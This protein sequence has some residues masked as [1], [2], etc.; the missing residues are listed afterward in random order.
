MAPAGARRTLGGLGIAAIVVAACNSLSGLD[1]DFALA[2]GGTLP[3]EGGAE[4]SSGSSGTSGSSGQNDADVP[5]TKTD[6]SGD[7][8]GGLDCTNPPAGPSGATLLFCDNFDDAAKSGPLWGW[9]RR[10]VT[11]GEPKVEPDIGFVARGLHAKATT[12][13]TPPNGG[14]LTALWKTVQTGLQ[15]GQ[16]ITLGLRFKIHS[17]DVD[18]TVIGAIQLN[19]LEYGVALY[20]NPSCPG[21]GRCVDE[22]DHAGGHDFSNGVPLVLDAWYA[23]DITVTRTGSAFGGKVV[24]TGAGAGTLDDRPSGVLPTGNPGAIEVGVGSFYSSDSSSADI[25]VDDVIVWRH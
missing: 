19:G 22:N 9:N 8:G 12:T 2:G 20:D 16:R 18:Y 15:D 5:D 3:G 24:V 21:G 23:A 7:G 17:A 6:A 10:Q 1:G 4:G 13:A 25:V 11:S 14:W